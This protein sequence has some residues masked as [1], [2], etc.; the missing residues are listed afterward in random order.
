[1]ALTFF[2][3]FFGRC[4][5]VRA[6]S[7]EPELSSGLASLAVTVSDERRPRSNS[8]SEETT[9]LE[10]RCVV[11]R[12]SMLEACFFVLIFLPLTHLPNKPR[13][14]FVQHQRLFAVESVP[15]SQLRTC[16]HCFN[17]KNRRQLS[18]ANACALRGQDARVA[19]FVR[20]KDVPRCQN[21]PFS[22]GGRWCA[23]GVGVCA[24]RYHALWNSR[25]HF[26]RHYCVV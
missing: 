16:Q 23:S 10:V 19:L 3:G 17:A 21:H 18:D 4:C 15:C 7:G 1:M 13:C 20:S 12:R 8:R 24:E 5:S 11:G 6:V 26:A 9:A 25:L 14:A 22:D 2:G